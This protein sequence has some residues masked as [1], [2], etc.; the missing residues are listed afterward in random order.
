MGGG[1]RIN[2]VRSL[3]GCKVKIEREDGSGVR[4]ITLIGEKKKIVMATYLVNQSISAYST[5]KPVN[6]KLGVTIRGNKS[7]YKTDI[8]NLS[9]AEMGGHEQ[10]VAAAMTAFFAQQF[11]AVP[12]VEPTNPNEYDPET[13]GGYKPTL[14]YVD[15]PFADNKMPPDMYTVPEKKPRLHY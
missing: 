10:Q 8:N 7:E 14:E 5:A 12:N 9:S 3:S 13:T 11:S 4:R 6:E 15:N 2:E 1:K